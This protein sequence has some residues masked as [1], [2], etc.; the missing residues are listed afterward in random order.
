MRRMMLIVGAVVVSHGT[1]MAGPAYSDC[2]MLIW[3]TP[4]TVGWCGPCQAPLIGDFYCAGTPFVKNITVTYAWCMKAP[5]G[6]AG[7]PGC[8]G[9]LTVVGNVVPCVLQPDFDQILVCMGGT[10]VCLL[11]CE[12]CLVPGAGLPACVPCLACL[13]TLGANCMGCDIRE[14]VLDPAGMYPIRE[15]TKMPKPGTCS[16]A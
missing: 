11:V 13:A 15:F 14:C 5:T 6:V 16:G 9:A 1:A 3:Q 2:C 12:T 10:D 4:A 7:V 8:N